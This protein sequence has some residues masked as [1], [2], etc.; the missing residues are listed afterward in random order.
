MVIKYGKEMDPLKR[1]RLAQGD[2]IRKARTPKMS[3]T[4]LAEACGVTPGAVTQWETGLFTPRQAMQIK[5]ARALDVP[6]SFLFGM[7]EVA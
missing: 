1:I 3:I 7:D 2:R 4:E 6:H 5:I